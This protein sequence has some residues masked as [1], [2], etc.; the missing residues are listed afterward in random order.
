VLFV[1][2]PPQAAKVCGGI[3]TW[4]TPASQIGGSF[5]VELGVMVFDPLSSRVW[6]VEKR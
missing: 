1:K 2:K 3:G 4:T 6:V 5:F